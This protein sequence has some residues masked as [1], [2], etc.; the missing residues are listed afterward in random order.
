MGGGEG[1]ED[2]GWEGVE[3]SLGGVGERDTGGE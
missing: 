3:K 2:A 1:V